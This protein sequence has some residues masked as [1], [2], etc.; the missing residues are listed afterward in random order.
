M[1]LNDVA[2]HSGLVVSFE[3]TFPD[4]LPGQVESTLDRLV[5]EALTTVVN[6]A[7]AT[8]VSIVLAR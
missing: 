6:H 8:T 4:R 7:R 5:Q 2:E 3:A 1:A